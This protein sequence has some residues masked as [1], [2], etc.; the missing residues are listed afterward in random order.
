MGQYGLTPQGPVTK[1]LD[2]ILDEIHNDLTE[3]WG[4]NTRH[5]P[6]SY[7]N[8]QVT[9]FADK[10]AELWELGMDIYHAMYPFSAENA[11]LD[12]AVQYGGIARESA[13]KTV[14]QI[15]AKC[16]DGTVI[17]QG[18]IIRSTTNPALDFFCERTT[19]VN[20][21]VFNVIRIRISALQAVGLYTVVLN[22]EM[23]NYQNDSGDEADVLAGLAEEIQ[24]PHFESRITDGFLEISAVDLETTN[25]CVL[26]SN[27]TTESV[28]GVVRY[29]SEE[30]GTV[31]LPNGT[32]TQIVTTVTGP[33]QSGQ[34]L[35][36]VINLLP[37]IAGQQVQNDK[38][39][40][41]SYID[42]I[43]LRS[44]SMVESIE[45]AI[46]ENVPGIRSVR[47]FQNDTHLWDE[48][49]RPPHSVEMVVD[50]GSSQEI[51]QQIWNRKAAGIQ[52]PFGNVETTVAGNEG[53]PVI[54]RFSRP[55]LVYVW[56]RI[57]FYLDPS[58]ILPPNYVEA[59]RDIIIERMATLR[60]GENVSS[61][62]LFI[63]RIHR[64]V[65]GVAYIQT[66]SFTT[67]DRNKAPGEYRR[68]LIEVTQR[69]LAI[70]DPTRIE[71]VIG[72]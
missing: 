17:P 6:N 47:G 33:V 52:S 30:Y 67:T 63:D 62:R 40:R 69:Q 56:F 12:N 31:V 20:R 55:E 51:A 36:E 65:P 53:E 46:W 15:H 58:Q 60:A 13:R 68:G 42:K 38:Q 44:S 54:I 59:T 27:L 57:I 45:S 43:F 29:Q 22:G 61:Q 66:E 16:I 10:I 14:Y 5:N 41:Q 72:A 37:L 24:H 18:S 3:G 11:D 26:S 48:Y 25:I 21:N 9:A 7:L 39:L 64:T 70:I 1:R 49:G 34:G 28:T 71:V 8:V 35:L 32:I 2:T 19:E 4:V 50:G 23:F